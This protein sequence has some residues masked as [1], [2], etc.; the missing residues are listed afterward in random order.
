MANKALEVN[1]LGDNMWIR[2]V[3]NGGRQVEIILEKI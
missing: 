1:I 3:F 2:E